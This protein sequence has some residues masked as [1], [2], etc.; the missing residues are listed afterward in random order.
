M[1]TEGLLGGGGRVQ[2]RQVARRGG[3]RAGGGGAQG[4][5]EP[6][7]KVA[8]AEK[9]ERA[10]ALAVVTPHPQPAV[11]LRVPI[12]RAAQDRAVPLVDALREG[13]QVVQLLP[14]VVG[15]R[16]ERTRVDRAV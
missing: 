12:R 6:R 14:G 13:V 4:L 9:Q 3:T 10:F 15:R 7:A 8:V 2:R 16:Q 11:A 5:G 1:T